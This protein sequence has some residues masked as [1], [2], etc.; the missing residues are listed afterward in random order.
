MAIKKETKE[1]GKAKDKE[2]KKKPERYYEAVG[3]RKTA[4]ARVRIHFNAKKGEITVNGKDFTE[5]FREKEYQD[6]LLSPLVKMGISEFTASVKTSGGGLRA[7]SY[8]AR[9]GLSRALILSNPESKSVL[10]TIGFLTRDS[11]RKERKKPGLKAA[12]R[13]PQW[14]KR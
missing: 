3:R 4:V 13:A 2:I 12:R 9:H 14:S 5:Y 1:K 6:V 11:R 8:A 10:K 7:Q